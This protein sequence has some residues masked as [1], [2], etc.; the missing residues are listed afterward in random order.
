MMKPQEQLEKTIGYKFKNESLLTLALTHSSYAHEHHLGDTSENERLEYL[1]DA[2]LELLSSDFLY[3]HYPDYREG[4]LT[5]IRAALV[6]EDSLGEIA[7]GID[8]GDYIYMTRGEEKTGGRERKSLLSDAF[9]ALIGAVYLDGG[10]DVASKFVE[11]FVLVNT[12][13][14]ALYHDA[15]SLLQEETQG[16]GMGRASYEIIDQSG[17][18]HAKV[19]TVAVY[20]NG[21]MMGTGTGNT[22]KDA[23]KKASYEALLKLKGIR[24]E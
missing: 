6:C 2:V 10:F 12:K 19:F 5:R 21:E 7:V 13:D 15:K 3:H 9:E 16:R 23:E 24:E 1:G 11:R 17:P 22:K 8:L 18:D 20:V 4:E 14:R